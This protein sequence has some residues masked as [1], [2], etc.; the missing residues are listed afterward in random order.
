MNNHQRSS[1]Q[2]RKN[3][4]AIRGTGSIIEQRL[5]KALWNKGYRYR[6]NYKSII[7]RP[8]IAFPSLKIAIFCDSEFWHGYD[9]EN[10]KFDFHINREFWW[11]KIKRNVDR[12]QNVN[13]ILD[14]EGWI[15]LRFWGKD[16]KKD[17]ENCI[18]QI[19]E[20]I[21]TRKALKSKEIG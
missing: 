13:S 18:C 8:D 20:V 1:E 10:R 17:L 16:I 3:M 9:W 7:G 4:Q 11:R 19:E 5:Q 15:V 2:T 12:D 6:K 14:K 21:K